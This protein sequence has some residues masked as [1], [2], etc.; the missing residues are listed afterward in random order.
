MD[1]KKTFNNAKWIIG[2]KIAQSLLQF[3]IGTLSARYLGP[4]NFGLINYA[5]SIVAI[6][7]PIMTL[8][9][10]NTLVQEYVEAPDKGGQILGTQLPMNLISAAA[11]MVGVVSFAA[12]AN[13]GDK[14]TILVCCLYSVTLLAQALE[15]PQYWFQAKLLSKHSSLA[16]LLAYIVV[17]LYKIWLLVTGKSVYWFA[18]SHAVEYGVAGLLM[19]AAYKKYGNQKLC[20]SFPLAKKMISKSRYYIVSSMMVT[21]FGRFAGILLVQM[22][23]EVENGYYAAAMTCTVITDFVFRAIIDTARPLAIES[24]KVSQ[25]VFEKTISRIYSLVTWLSIAQSV[26]FTVFAV[27]IIGVLYGASYL[28]AV[29]VLQILCWQT[30][31]SYMGTIRNIWIL[32]EEKHQVLWKINLCGAIANILLNACMIPL[33]GAC[34]AAAASVVTQ[35]FTNVIMGYILKPI[36][37]NNRLLLKGLHPGVMIELLKAVL[38]K[39]RGRS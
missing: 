31:F 22:Q 34:G 24:R 27:L 7:T 12:V 18:L 25:S 14:T 29:P 11:C 35:L 21:V 23:G 26:G 2:C 13:P 15:M 30:A 28:P 20:F 8:G 5:S 38:P 9:F 19:L 4:G 6:V 39:Y 37:P 17:S 33:W 3:V 36:R 32:A 10:S 1:R 16:M